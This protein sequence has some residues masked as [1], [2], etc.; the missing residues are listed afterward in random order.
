MLTQR[1]VSLASAF[2]EQ[3]NQLQL[4]PMKTLELSQSQAKVEKLIQNG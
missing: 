3:A 4:H 1:Q 2:I